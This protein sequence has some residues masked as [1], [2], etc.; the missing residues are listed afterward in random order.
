MDCIISDRSFIL[1]VDDDAAHAE[2]VRQL[3]LAHQYLVEVETDPVKALR[4]AEA[5]PPA[6]LVL[7]LNMPGMSGVELLE[8]LVQVNR[9]TKAIVVSGEQAHTTMSPLL[10]L[11]AYDFISK[12]F[13]PDQLLR[14][15]GRALEQWQLEQDHS[16]MKLREERTNELNRFLLDAFPDLLYMLDKEGNFSFINN[17]LEYVFEADRTALAG[18]SWQTLFNDPVLRARLQNQINERREGSRKTRQLEFEVHSRTGGTV[19][20]QC[21]ARGLYRPG[22]GAA[23][24]RFVGTY[25][26]LQDVTDAR[27]A[28]REQLQ[29]QRKFQALVMESPDAVFISRADSGDVLEAN[30]LFRAWAA[31]DQNTGKSSDKST[32]K[33]SDKSTDHFLWPSAAARDEFISALRRSPEHLSLSVERTLEGDSRY[34]EINARLLE[35]EDVDCMLATVRDRS[36]ERQIELQ[37]QELQ[38]QLQQAGKMEA[39]GQLAGGIAHDFNNI[40]ASIIGYAELVLTSRHRL[41]G[42]KIDG[43]LREVVT[44]GH[45]ARDLISQ[46][47]TFTRASHGEARPVDIGEAIED[48]SRMLRAAIPST[49][50]IET[51]LVPG[52]RAVR[53]DPMQF[54]Q[55]IMNLMINARDSITGTGRITLRLEEADNCPDCQICG[56]R[57]SGRHVIVSVEDTGHGIKPEDLVH[58]FEM[59]FT[60]RE[61]GK[62]TGI[63]LWLVDGMVHTAGGHLSVDSVP[64]QGTRFTLHLPFEPEIKPVVTTPTSTNTVA[65]R[66]VVV[67]DEVTVSSF[68]GEILRHSGFETVVFNESPK[69]LDYLVRHLDEVALLLTDQAMPML[70]GLDLAEFVKGRKPEMPVVLITGFSQAHDARRLEEIG[71]D[72]Y[73]IKPF[74]IETLLEVV[75]SATRSTTLINPHAE[76]TGTI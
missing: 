56:E 10:R 23:A 24:E 36:R 15:V 64:G 48:V 6:I 62:G 37:Q 19:L 13:A 38:F 3:L 44:A 51:I 70:S 74:G 60:T 11:G 41:D 50:G 28:R 35:L 59:Y 25:G 67:D 22:P 65:G 26:V 57:I 66:I 21:S 2:S 54:Q 72:H 31:A 47:L 53:L 12:P 69:A 76:I 68:L 32:D 61:P 17:R 52:L 45:R 1:V 18:R 58:I 20:I 40:L 7:D 39:L 55:V 27:R 42:T 43:Y 5:N 8:K 49:I 73:L 29:S 63:G 16:A 4:R 46:M 75:R 71:V 30:E 9:S 34:L 14:S 33:S